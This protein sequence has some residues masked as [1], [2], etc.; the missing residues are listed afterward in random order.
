MT[1]WHFADEDGRELGSWAESIVVERT[2]VG[3]RLRPQLLS[4]D[5]RLEA[6]ERVRAVEQLHLSRT[7]TGEEW[8]ALTS[9]WSLVTGRGHSYRGET[10][11]I[12]GRDLGDLGA[13]RAERFGIARLPVVETG[14]ETLVVEIVLVRDARRPR[15]KERAR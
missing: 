10:T 15:R 3:I 6:L 5:V 2:T 14:G 7:P 11:S 1:H 12:V 9:A 8:A 4:C 13:L